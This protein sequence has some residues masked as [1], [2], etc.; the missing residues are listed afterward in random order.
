MNGRS[1]W[2]ISAPFGTKKSTNGFVPRPIV[3]FSFPEL[4][5]SAHLGPVHRRSA[6]DPLASKLGSAACL[7]MM[8]IIAPILIASCVAAE[9]ALM[10]RI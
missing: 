3:R 7:L 8:A 10:L 2:T 1:R 5:S 9:P 4:I 6:R